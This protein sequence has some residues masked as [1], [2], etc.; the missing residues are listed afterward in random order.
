MLRVRVNRQREALATG[1]E[2]RSETVMAAVKVLRDEGWSA[3][4]I[5]NFLDNLDVQLTIT[6]H[7]TE[8]R[9]YTVRLKLERI[10]EALRQLTETDVSPVRR[11]QLRD[12]LRAEIAALWQPRELDRKSVV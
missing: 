8:V 1:E 7:P 4:D 12:T 2:P 11:A 9:R 3:T 6:A 5:R 10:G